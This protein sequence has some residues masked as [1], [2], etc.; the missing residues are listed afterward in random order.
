MFGQFKVA[1]DMSQGNRKC[2]TTSEKQSKQLKIG[3]K[4]MENVKQ[5]QKNNQSS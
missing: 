2:K 3:L 1:K 4:L 5:H